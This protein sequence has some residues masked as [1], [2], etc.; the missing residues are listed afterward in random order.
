MDGTNFEIDDLLVEHISLK[1]IKTTK[2]IYENKDPIFT[3]Y[4]TK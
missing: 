2:V 1:K 3:T 4:R